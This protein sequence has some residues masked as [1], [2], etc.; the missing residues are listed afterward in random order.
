MQNNPYAAPTVD[1]HA[2]YVRS[3]ENE[4]E[5]REIFQVLGVAWTTLKRE[6]L[7][8]IGAMLLMGICLYAVILGPMFLL[9]PTGF[10]GGAFQ[11]DPRSLESMMTAMWALMPIMLLAETFF[12]LGWTRFTIAAVREQP[13]PLALNFVVWAILHLLTFGLIALV[14]FPIFSLSLAE[15]YV[16]ATG[17]HTQTV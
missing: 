15:I 7:K 4:P 12:M 14:F 13:L 2:S 8:I 3:G 9:L 6:P 1:P 16:C 5:S 10:F 11:P 17:R